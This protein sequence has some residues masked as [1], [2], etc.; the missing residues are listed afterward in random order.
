[1]TRWGGPLERHDSFLQA[2]SDFREMGQAGC[3]YEP[4]SFKM[5]LSW[6]LAQAGVNKA[7]SLEAFSYCRAMLVQTKSHRA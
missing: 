4:W 2:G 7:R 1:M 3:L 6:V 5:A